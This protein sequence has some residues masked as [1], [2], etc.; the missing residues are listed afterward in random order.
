MYV[1]VTVVVAPA[2]TGTEWWTRPLVAPVSQAVTL[3]PQEEKAYFRP[4]F[5]VVV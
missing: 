5:S 3:P 1:R 2:A 4:V